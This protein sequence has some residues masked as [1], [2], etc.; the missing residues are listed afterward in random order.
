MNTIPYL[1][2]HQQADAAF[3]RLYHNARLSPGA[4]ALAQ[5]LFLLA[6][7]AIPPGSVAVTLDFLSRRLSQSVHTITQSKAELVRE[8]I[9]WCEQCGSSVR[10]HLS[11]LQPPT[12]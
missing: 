9:I 1:T 8:K 2:E 4:L 6:M 7:R 12:K 3:G 11:C 5:T 10:Y